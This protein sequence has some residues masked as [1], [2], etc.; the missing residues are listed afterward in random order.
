MPR[1]EVSIVIE[2]SVEDVFAFVENPENDPIWRQ[3]MVE[4][5]VESED[6]EEENEGESEGVGATGREV[7]MLMG[8]R[9][10]TTW[11]ITEYEPNRKVAYKSTS[12]PVTY[13]GAWTYEEEDGGTRV[14]FEI[15]WDIVNRETFGRLA[16]RVLGITHF[17]S[18]DGNLQALKKLLEA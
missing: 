10:E 15:D 2:R 12:G 1:Y 5:V 16:E 14:T 3:S 6:E 4:S 11:E 9:I 18:N 8:R 13:E 7:Y 17:Q